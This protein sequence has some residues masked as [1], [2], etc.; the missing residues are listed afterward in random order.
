MFVRYYGYMTNAEKSRNVLVAMA[1]PYANGSLHLGHIASFVGADVLARYHRL[2]GGEVLFVSGSDCYG[3]PIALEAVAQGVTPESIAEKYHAEFCDSLDTLSFSFD[4]YT[5]TT[6]PE[7]QKV[8]QDIFLTLHKAGHIYTKTEKALYSPALQRFLPDRFV[9]GACPYCGFDGARGDQC[10]GC[11]KLLDP[12]LLKHPRINPKVLGGK[13]VSDQSL[14]VRESEQFYLKLTAFQGMLEQWLGSVG[15]S[16][17]V[18]AAQFTKGF[19]KQGLQ[20]RAITRDT[21]WGV[22][23]PIDGYEEKRIYV[24]FEAVLGY[25]SAAQHCTQSRGDADGWKQW[26]LSDDAAHYYVHGKDNVPFHSIIL[27]AILMGAG[28]Y[29]LPDRL[30]SSEYLTLEGEQFSTSRGHAVWV[31]DFLKD[32]DAELLRYYML[33]QGPETADADFRWAEFG[34]MVNGELI[35]TFGNLVNRICAFTQKNFPDG[36]SCDGDLDDAA[37]QL[38]ADVEKGFSVV[39]AHIEAGQFRQGFREILKIAESANRFA[40]TKEPWKHLDD[41]KRVHTDASVLLHTILNLAL[42]VQPFLPK[43]SEAI[44]GFFGADVVGSEPG[45]S[46]ALSAWRYLPLP[47]TFVLQGVTPLFTKI[48]D[49]VIQKQVERLAK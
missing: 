12:L 18:N 5:K 30:F 9:E 42:L 28:E 17:R 25:L 23:I 11:G 49:A 10:D 29:H 19:L 24:W 6:T 8:V 15:D 48:E 20:D 22:P 41:T 47:K 3:T 16:W 39:G 21:D 13:E 4:L 43:T 31:P 2:K 45:V 44:Q 27:P 34:Q 14:E 38:L 26:F 1:W 33:A 32:F 46:H 7:H 36:V 40:H 37:K 35:G